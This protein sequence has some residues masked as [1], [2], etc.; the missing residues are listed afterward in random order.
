MSDWT[1]A[2]ADQSYHNI[3]DAIQALDLTDDRAAERL[4]D[5]QAELRHIEDQVAELRLLLLAATAMLKAAG[6]WDPTLY[7]LLKA[8]LDA[9]D[10]AV[11]G[12]LRKPLPPAERR[13]Q[14][15]RAKQIHAISRRAAGLGIA[16]RGF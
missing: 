2:L 16:R 6:T 11:D 12:R 14:V 7:D 1:V 4:A 9:A 8:R 15:F 13:P 3:W 10:G 5:Q